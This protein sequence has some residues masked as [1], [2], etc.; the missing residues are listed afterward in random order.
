M[1][2]AAAMA[3]LAAP[4]HGKPRTAAP[5]RIVSLNLCTDQLLV[6]IADRHQI[7]G[8][9]PN[10]RKPEMSTIADQVEGLPILGRSAEEVLAIGPD[11]VIGMPARRSG[12][13]MALR[14][15]N[16]PTLDLKSAR[17][18][19]QILSQIEKMA[20]ATGHPERGQALVAQME[21][22]LAALPK[23]G[24]GRVA[25]FYQR[26][27]FLTGTGTLI[28]DLMERLGLVNLAAKLGKPVLAR[29]SLEELVAAQPDFLIIE[30]DSEQVSDHGTEMLHHPAIAGIPRISLPQAWTVCGGPAYVLA[31]KRLTDALAKH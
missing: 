8:L 14:S 22:D 2:L 28:D 20:V 18:L 21:R 25:A 10:A 5:E 30:E 7:A 15:E 11:L 6:A 16:Y 1:I 31:A 17:N 13:M 12:I 29:L 3:L 4:V 26:R 27:G 9:T 24:R 19:P 23:N